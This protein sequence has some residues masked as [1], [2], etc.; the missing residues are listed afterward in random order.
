ARVI[1]RHRARPSGCVCL[2]VCLPVSL[3]LCLA[4]CLSAC[5]SVYLSVSLPVSL[6]VCLSF[7]HVCVCRHACDDSCGVQGERISGLFPQGERSVNNTHTLSHTYT[8][9]HTH[10]HTK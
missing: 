8:H 1:V 9:T 7:P 2:S 4:A 3:S 5:L 10:T 6:P